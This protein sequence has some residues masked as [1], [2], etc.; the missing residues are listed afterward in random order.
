MNEFVD[1]TELS[2]YFRALDAVCGTFEAFR[3]PRRMAVS[4]GA[5]KAL[6]I[7]RPGDAGTPW[8]AE[9]T[10]YMVE[11]MDMQASRAHAGLV[12][13]GPAQSGKTVGLGEGWMAHVVTNDPG[14]M[15]MVQMTEGKAREY[16]RQRIDRALT[17]SDM[18]RAMRGHAAS[19]NLHDKQFKHGM[20]LKIAWPTITNLSSTSYRYVFLTDFDRMPEDID[21]EGDAFTLGMKRTTTFLSRGMCCVESSPGYPFIDPAWQAST[22]HE[23]PPTKGILGVYNRSDRR[24][25][26]WK[27]RDCCEWFEAAPG[28]KLF[29][30]PGD[31]ELLEI[32]R[33][34][35]LSALARKYARIIC[36]HCAVVINFDQRH[37]LNQGGRWLQDGLRLTTDDEVVGTAMN[38]TIAGYW[39]GG[40]AAAYQSWESLLN[41]YFQ[42]LREY[43]LNGSELALQTS[44]NT[45]QAMPYMSRHL[46]E[47][48]N[49]M[50]APIDRTEDDHKRFIVP[51]WA[52]SILVSVDVQGGST[53]RFVCQAHAVGPYREQYLLD[54]FEIRESKREGF[55]GRMAP[56]DPA[57]YAEDWDILTEKIVR[58]T[59]RTATEGRELR[60]KLCIIDAN[61]EDGVTDRA[62]AWYRRLRIAGLQSRVMLTRGN[63]TK[64]DW[65]IKETLVGRRNTKEEGDVPLYLLNP[66]LLKDIVAVGLKRTT[67]GP[68]YFHFPTPKGPTNPNGWLSR[69]FFDE[70]NANVRGEDGI[71]RAIRKRDETSDLCHMIAAGC[72]R[73]GLD[74]VKW[75]DESMLPSWLLPL[76]RN[77]EIITDVQRREIKATPVAVA[78]APVRRRSTSSYLK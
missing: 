12:F 56:I 59:Y 68:G 75:D 18:L 53:A 41:K 19:D 24:R 5:A 76:D 72:L 48:A 31:N 23:A 50:T 60:V 51:D 8:S 49:F 52:R 10:P 58:A 29:K 74:K 78:E 46:L 43:A 20:W 61:G 27:C 55:G 66:H 33:E 25:W 22:P 67:P 69:S 63:N 2:P 40:V 45:D 17:H 39:L 21:G 38:S 62:Y 26:Y 65:L 57:G 6:V 54:R 16:S 1:T 14:D 7:K 3:P 70:L 42:G 73:L 34:A 9:R 44:V 35:D 28:L 36:P 77:T 11:P 64:T 15:L 32:A 37:T 47:S 13:V 4:E 30:L 71:W